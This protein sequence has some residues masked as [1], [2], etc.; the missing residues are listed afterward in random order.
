GESWDQAQRVGRWGVIV[1]GERLVRGTRGRVSTENIGL[2]RLAEGLEL[3]RIGPALRPEIAAW[4]YGDQFGRRRR[5][6]ILYGVGGVTVLT[7]LVIGGLFA[8]AAYG[9]VLGQSGNIA[10]LIV[11]ARTVLKLRTEDGKVIKLRGM[12]IYNTVFLPG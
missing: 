2:A 12:D 6:A 11:N 9:A 4:R 1:E 7:T 10:N 5:R 3:V 8:G